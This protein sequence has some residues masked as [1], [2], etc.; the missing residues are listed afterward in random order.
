MADLLA[1]LIALLKAD[2]PTASIA[3]GRI[4][5]AELPEAETAS[6]P[7][8]AIVVA[9]SGGVSLTGGS[10]LEADTQRVDLLAYG[11]TPWEAEALRDVAGLAL[12]RVRRSV[13]AGVLIH[14]I[15]PAGGSANARDPDLAWPRAFQSFQVFHALNAVV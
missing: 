5:G 15:K 6:M 13:W 12:R 3:E 4:F 10:Y 2:V 8:A 1:G 11:A 7:R 9:T 14:W